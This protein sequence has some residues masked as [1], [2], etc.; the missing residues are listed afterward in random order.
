MSASNKT[1]SFEILTK[2]RVQKCAIICLNP[3]KECST[4]GRGDIFFQRA[5]KD[6]LERRSACSQ[7]LRCCVP[8]AGSALKGDPLHIKEVKFHKLEE[9]D[10]EKNPDL[11]WMQC[12]VNVSFKSSNV[13]QKL[14]KKQGCLSHDV[15]EN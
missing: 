1:G 10:A 3:L 15:M 13:E 2:S 12:S 11:V 7:S 14:N 6:V 5:T 8:A 9:K 4:R